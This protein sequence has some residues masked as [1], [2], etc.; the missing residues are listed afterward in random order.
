MAVFAY[1]F[2]NYANSAP[3]AKAATFGDADSISTYAKDA[4][5]ALSGAGIING[6]GD[7]NFAPGAFA[8]RAQ[9]AKIIYNVLALAKRI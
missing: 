4:V 7:G 2:L 6:M 8:T 5:G 9:A 1:R 3:E